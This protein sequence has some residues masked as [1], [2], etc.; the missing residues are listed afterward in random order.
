MLNFN[1]HNGKFTN[2]KINNNIGK[3]AKIEANLG[4]TWTCTKSEFN[5]AYQKAKKE[6]EDDWLCDF[7]C[8]FTPCAAA[9]LAEAVRQCHEC[10]FTF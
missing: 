3:N 10:I 1:I 4:C 5:A 8:T 6:C 2:F 9:Y 7:A